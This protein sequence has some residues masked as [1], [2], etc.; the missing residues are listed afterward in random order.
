MEG[1]TVVSEYLTCEKRQV[2]APAGRGGWRMPLLA[3]ISAF[4]L[5]GCATAAPGPPGADGGT[6]VPKGPVGKAV[7]A[8]SPQTTATV[9]PMLVGGASDFPNIEALYNRLTETQ[10]EESYVPTPG[11]A[12][13]WSISPDGK[14][15]EFQIRK[16]IRFHNGDELTPEDVVFTMQRVQK[17]GS[18]NNKIYLDRYVESVQASGDTVVFKLKEPDWLVIT[19]LSGAAY[20]IVPKKYVE[21]VGDEGF[22]K[23]PVGTGPFKMVS[24]S[25]QESLDLE[26]VDSE[27]FFRQPGVKQLRYLVVGEET[28]RLAMVKTQE[29]DLAQASVMSLKAL[30]G[31]SSVR[32]IRVPYI[33]G[34]VLFMFGQADRSNP[35]SKVEL[36]QALSLAIDREA[37]ARGI[38]QGYARPM[39]VPA[40]DPAAA[41]LP[42]WGKAVIK[43][44]TNKASE[45]LGKAGFPGGKGLKLTL[46]N[47][48]YGALPLWTQ[49]A[50]VIASDWGKLGIQVEMRQW[51]WGSWAPA[52]RS[53]KLD[54]VS[55]GTHLANNSGK[56]GAIPQFTRYNNYSGAT[57]ARDG[58]YPQ[59]TEWAEQFDNEFDPAKRAALRDKVLEFDRD[60]VVV[61][62]VVSQDGL[63]LA[64]ARVLEYKPR[65]AI[66]SSGNLW[67]IRVK[68]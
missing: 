51:E 34:L 48:E 37:I 11:V 38:Y 46:H 27:H 68:P 41:D 22:L 8:L 10:E 29:A 3:A 65:P 4:L 20:S 55:V 57:G 21:R 58:A 9:D 12:E 59:L 23:A 42:E 2:A 49:V 52:A 54:P 13:K 33:G 17:S 14:T 39:T 19:A 24:W 45:L 61:L 64:G 47:Y 32:P 43:Q 67:T 53:T 25:K 26:A 18:P 50:P 40:W 15:V 36:R 5:G 16:G 56:K 1:G 28:T 30:Q 7:L 66:H 44:D 35:L 62:P 6:G 31:D 60:N 63:W